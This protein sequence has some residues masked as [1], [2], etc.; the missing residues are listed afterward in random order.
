MARDPANI[1]SLCEV[2]D[3]R[4]LLAAADEISVEK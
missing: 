1:E 3:R 2:R 4:S